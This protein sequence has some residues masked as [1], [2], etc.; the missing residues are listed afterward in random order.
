MRKFR[1]ILMIL[2]LLLLTACG[3]VTEE[4]ARQALHNNLV[5]RYGEEFEIGYMGRRS[6]GKETWYEAEIY[7]SKYKGT[8]REYDKYYRS[9]GSVDIKKG[10]FGESIDYVGDIYRLVLINESAN[11]FYLPKLK[12]LFGENVLP[13][14]EIDISE[15][16]IVPNFIAD[17]K[18]G[19]EK[20]QRP[21]IKGGIY[22][23]GRVENDE[24]REWY[25]K[26]IYEF[27]QFMKQTGTFEYVDLSFQIL[28]ERILIKEFDEIKPL[29]I[30]HFNTSANSEEFLKYREKELN[31][32]NEKYKQLTLDDKKNKINNYSK[33][34]ISKFNNDR[35]L[36]YTALYHTVIRSPKFLKN[37][38]RLSKYKILE[39]KSKD[40]IKLLNTIKI[41]FDEYDKEKIYKNEW[42]D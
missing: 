22:I 27:V 4:E 13:V 36:G 15:L 12:E 19:L 21:K 24:D 1:R 11:E 18:E 39:Y 17:Y 10:I 2:I 40:E 16:E 3:R 30:N 28:D 25:R 29:L 41:I 31:K 34:E 8:P 26:Q 20:N 9:S 38:S 42:G 7:P 35:F 33:S 6:D 37:E 14:L 5:K 23:F 32:L